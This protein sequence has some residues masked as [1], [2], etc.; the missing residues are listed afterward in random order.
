[1]GGMN[2]EREEILCLSFPLKHSSSNGNKQSISN[3]LFHETVATTQQR[4]RFQFQ[5][6]ISEPAGGGDMQLRPCFHINSVVEFFSIPP[7]AIY[8]RPAD[9]HIFNEFD[10]ICKRLSQSDSTSSS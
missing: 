1:M 9:A 2:S 10:S 7:Y 6:I 8:L 3:L 5:D 4:A